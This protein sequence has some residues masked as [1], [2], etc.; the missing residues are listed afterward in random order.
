ML[1]EVVGET[2]GTIRRLLVGATNADAVG[3]DV[4]DGVG[5]GLNGRG[6][7]QEKRGREVVNMRRGRRSRQEVVED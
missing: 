4:N 3:G 1:L 5:I 2:S 6:A 7:L